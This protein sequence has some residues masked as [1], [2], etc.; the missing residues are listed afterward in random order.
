[1]TAAKR[2]GASTAGSLGRFPEPKNRIFRKMFG[3]CRSQKSRAAAGQADLSDL[4]YP[5]DQAWPDRFP[6]DSLRS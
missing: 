4:T 2:D 1:M 6:S 5:P 3:F